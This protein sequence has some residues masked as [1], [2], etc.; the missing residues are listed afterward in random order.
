MTDS[1][2]LP[3]IDSYIDGGVVSGCPVVLTAGRLA[4]MQHLGIAGFASDAEPDI[5][6]LFAAFFV[7]SEDNLSAAVEIARDDTRRDKV[8]RRWRDGFLFKTTRTAFDFVEWYKAQMDCLPDADTGSSNSS[9]DRTWLDRYVDTFASQYGWS[10]HHIMWELPLVVGIRLQ[11]RIGARLGVDSTSDVTQEAIDLIEA[12]EAAAEA[13]K[14]D[15]EE[16]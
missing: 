1:D 6:D 10:R 14:Q 11:E 8:L 16:S 9:D 3:P 4:I 5:D 7:C 2:A 13:E 15:G 12:A